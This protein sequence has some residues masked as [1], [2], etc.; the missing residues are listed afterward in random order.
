MGGPAADEAN[1][2]ARD[3]ESLGSPERLALL[4]TLRTPKVLSE[5]HLSGPT[6]D[7][8][9][10]QLFAR[11]TVRYHLDRLIASGLVDVVPASRNGRPTR[12]YVFR[13]DRA[14]LLAEFLQ[15][16]AGVRRADRGP[17]GGPRPRAPS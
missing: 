17:V 9:R 12:S 8:E 4:R 13:P 1:R 15:E 14:H 5:I 2:M 10:R 3:L 6:L 7:R 11:Q 16:L